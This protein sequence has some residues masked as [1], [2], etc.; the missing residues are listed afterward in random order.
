M[1]KCAPWPLRVMLEIISY[2]QHS[3]RGVKNIYYILG[4]TSIQVH[5]YFLNIN[6]FT[7]CR[8]LKSVHFGNT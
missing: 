3:K 2:L 5:I 8:P 1:G 4:D 6:A 7:C